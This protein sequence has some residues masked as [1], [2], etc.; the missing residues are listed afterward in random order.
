MAFLGT[1]L[2][3]A[4]VLSA[5]AYTLWPIVSPPEGEALLSP[6]EGGA[7][8]GREIARL[9]IDRDRAYRNI[10]EIEFDREMGK[11]SEEDYGEMIAPARAR[12]IEVLRRLEACG[13][14]EGMV[15]V[16]VDEREAPRAAEDIQEAAVAAAPVAAAP[17]A[18][19]AAASVGA[20]ERSLDERLEKEILRYRKVPPG[21]PAPGASTLGEPAPGAQASEEAARFCPS[22]GSPV[23]PGH[24]FCA[25]CGTGLK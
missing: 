20:R 16:H 21:A 12:A 22:C 17:A 3:A 14:G 9:L 11:L 7:V 19:L 15:A 24:K 13:V 2:A 10:Q 8:D 5:F 23:S 4:L 1:A 25:S 6:E 18:A